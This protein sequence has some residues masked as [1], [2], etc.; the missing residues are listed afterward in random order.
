MTEEESIL[1]DQLCA[2]RLG[3][4]HFRLQQVIDGFIVDFYCHKACLVVEVDCPIHEKQA[5]YDLERARILIG[6]GLRILRIKNEEIRQD[7][8]GVLTRIEK[9]IH[10]EPL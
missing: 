4:F 10:T 5:K 1:W 2:N 8:S 6:R 7:L 9:G 3:D